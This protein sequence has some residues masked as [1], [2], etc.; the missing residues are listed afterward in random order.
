MREKKKKKKV[1]LTNMCKSAPP[2]LDLAPF[3]RPVHRMEL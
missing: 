3:E 1:K 2:R